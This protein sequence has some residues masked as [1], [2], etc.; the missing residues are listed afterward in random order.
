M[1][2]LERLAARR[3][4][5]QLRCDVQRAALAAAAAPLRH[6][7]RTLIGGLRAHPVLV[8]GGVALV[9][10]LRPRRLRT[11]VARGWMAW[12]AWRTWQS[13]RATTVKRRR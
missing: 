8:A 9:V 7:G 13:G 2:R 10:A 12:Q 1:S 3:E 4:A 5:L 11:W 6:P